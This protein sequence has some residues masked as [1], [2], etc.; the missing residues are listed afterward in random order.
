MVENFGFWPLGRLIDRHHPA[1]G[2]LERLQGNGRAL[3]AATW[4]HAL[5]GV[6]L[7]VLEQR[8]NRVPSGRTFQL[9]TNREAAEDE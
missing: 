2:E 4:R 1:R 6:V 3:A 7:G 8:F 5:F 9:E